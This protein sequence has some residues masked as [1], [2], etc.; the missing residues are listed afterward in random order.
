MRTRHCFVLAAVALLTACGSGDATTPHGSSGTGGAGG[1]QGQGGD[2]VIDPSTTTSSTGSGAGTADPCQGACAADQHCDE[3]TAA[4]VNNTCADLSCGPKERC[5]PT[6]TGGAICE[7]ISCDND[8]DCP[9][10]QYCD[11]ASGACQEDTCAAGE[12]TCAGEVLRACAA[13]GGSE[14]A[15]FTC[16]SQSYFE[17]TCTDPGDG[18]ASCGCEDDWDCPEFTQ[19]DGSACVGTGRA[20][21]CTLP[22]AAFTDVL[23]QEEFHWG[24]TGTGSPDAIDAPFPIYSQ[25]SV[26]PMV[27]NLDD[28]NG[29]GLINE[30]DFPEI[31]FTTFNKEVYA[32]D[33]VIRAIH[34][35]GP[36]KGKD[37]FA[38]CGDV[39]WHEGDPLSMSCPAGGPIAHGFAMLAVGDL[40]NDGVPEIVAPTEDAGLAILD[41]RGNIITRTAP[42]QWSTGHG[43]PSPNLA[44]LDQAGM[45]EI[46]VGNR[47][48]TL[49]HDSAGKLAF[50]D[51]F[52]GALNVGSA[53]GPVSCVANV[54]G[55]SKLEVVAGTTAY[56]LPK[57]PSGVT[58]RSECAPGATDAFCAGT[59]EVLWDGQTVN[60]A[61]LPAAQA[62]GY[63]AIADVLGANA[64]LAPSPSNPLDG[65]PEAVY[66]AKGYLVILDGETGALLRSTEL[67]TQLGTEQ[68]G[69]GAPN[70]DDFD[71]DGFPEIGT[72]FGFRY[73]LHDLQEPSASC[74]AWPTA[75][76][77]G[78]ANTNPARTPGGACTV[79]SD[80]ASGAVCNTMA[81]LCTCLHNGWQ[82]ITEDD[83]SGTTSSSVFDFNGDGAAEVVYND[84]CNF[85]V[86]NGVNGG[87]YYKQHSPSL[88]RIENP[89]IADVDN[90][91]NAEIV[92]ASNNGGARCSTSIDYPNG[93]TVLGDSH[94][95]WV[96]AR[97]VWNQHAYHVT[98]VT[99]SGSI[100]VEEPESWK[101]YNGRRYNTYRSNPRS[102]GVAP[103]LVLSGINVSSPDAT[104]G[105]LSKKLD[106]TVKV[107]NQG[108]LRVGPGIIVGFYGTWGGVESAL[109][110]GTGSP[111]T[112]PLSGSLEPG[113]ALLLTASY[114]ANDAPSG[115]LPDSVRVKVD[116]AGSER[117]CVETNNEAST[118]VTAG[119]AGPDLTVSLGASSVS[120]CPAPTL[121][122]TVS[123][124]GSAP[125]SSIVVRYYA[126]DPSAGGVAFHTETV[127]GPIN[128]GQST[129]FTASLTGFPLNKNIV[130]YAVV[131]PDGVI[132]ECNAGNN[133]DK[134][135][136]AYGCGLIK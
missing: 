135:G 116:D 25:A 69:G 86:Y 108:D 37:Y 33:G 113:Y 4:C 27:M 31:I 35:G 114:D 48:F 89:S 18:K 41:N 136:S 84:E 22:P 80:C 115:A 88:T 110:D 62:D 8:V 70:I 17:S 29:D 57:P 127:A 97:R 14:S 90:D 68:V 91:G 53:G 87:V 104:C 101:A 72:A 52:D 92:F 34:G 117:E 20:P 74:P 32:K 66:I 24:G 77:D 118:P 109:L 102:S 98:N 16:G 73:L 2:D 36:N 60:G 26:V 19:C 7:D 99:E 126:G 121:I 134:T 6:P 78:A 55:D 120:S 30:M 96:S 93:I 45:V 3:G 50:L 58:R 15:K 79:D 94:D 51:R 28:D 95:T 132:E 10:T 82:S 67:Y 125:A 23:P 75:I 44:N 85:R 133:Q 123:N 130:V 106:I 21:T 71:G 112:I 9:I 111:I 128:A 61:S 76:A 39:V 13:N 46:I 43:A 131:N 129:T 124:V 65:R 63:C 11:T 38:N 5:Q 12:T 42:S 83:A 47:V 49:E 59:L 103:D 122:T 100:P 107:E 119:V 40:D 1:G 105:E 54:A 56:V 81:G 64:A